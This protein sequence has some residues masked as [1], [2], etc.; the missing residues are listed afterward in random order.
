MPN[1]EIRTVVE[2]DVW[3]KNYIHKT[4]VRGEVHA[5]WLDLHVIQDSQPFDLTGLEIHAETTKPDGT[6]IYNNVDLTDPI[7][8][9]ASFELTSQISAVVGTLF[10]TFRLIGTNPISDKRIL[11]LELEILD[12]G[13]DAQ[14]VS[15]NEFTVLQIALDSIASSITGAATAVSNC[16]TA[17]SACI[18]ATDNADV[19]A[20][21]ARNLPYVGTD[22]YWYE[23]D[24]SQLKY[25]KT[26]AFASVNYATFEID[27]VT[28][29]LYE[30]T[31]DTYTGASFQINSSGELEAV[32]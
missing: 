9:I 10:F 26:N 24:G 22:G 3:N 19:S 21:I 14:I 2:A 18:I 17:T 28:G 23:Y 16:N 32:I 4:A 1:N 29:I 5:R 31:A 25:V 30:Y 13:D 12:G 20:N 27:P 15:S 6:R 7:N 8:G 11:G